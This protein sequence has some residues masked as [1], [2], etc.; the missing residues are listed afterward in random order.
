MQQILTEP[1]KGIRCS[2]EANK[3]DE[4]VALMELPF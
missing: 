2:I 4:A 1:L 3:P